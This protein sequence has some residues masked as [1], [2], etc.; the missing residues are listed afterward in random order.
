MAGKPAV[1]HRARAIGRKGH[2]SRSQ[3]EGGN[4]LLKAA[5]CR[6]PEHARDRVLPLLPLH[7]TI[8]YVDL[9]HV[10]VMS[11]RVATGSLAHPVFSITILVLHMYYVDAYSRAM[12]FS[13]G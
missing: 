11:R 6:E 2:A 7:A 9:A 12:Q 3:P 5:R 13:R 10:Y 8:T 4:A 1:R